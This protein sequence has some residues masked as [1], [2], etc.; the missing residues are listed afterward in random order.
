MTKTQFNKLS[1]Y[2]RRVILAKDVLDQLRAE[3][4]RE[5]RGTYVGITKYPKKFRHNNFY[6]IDLSSKN[7]QELLNDETSKCNVCAKG[8]MICSYASKFDSISEYKAANGDSAILKKA[9]GSLFW[10]V[11]ELLFEGWGSDG[12]WVESKPL[13]YLRLL[14]IEK[15]KYGLEYLMRNIVRNKGILKI[16]GKVIDGDYPKQR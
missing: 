8:A 9:V 12:Y 6:G 7:F 13:R 4:I 15:K 16:N 3:K 1:I 14:K 2:K 11:L 5:K 10:D